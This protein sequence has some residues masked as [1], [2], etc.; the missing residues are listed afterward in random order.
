MLLVLS[1]QFSIEIGYLLFF[2]FFLEFGRRR[3]WCTSRGTCH[4]RLC[5]GDSSFRRFLRCID[6]ASENRTPAFYPTASKWTP[7]FAD[8][9]GASIRNRMRT[10]VGRWQPVAGQTRCV[11]VAS[12]IS[13]VNE[14]TQSRA[15]IVQ[16]AL[17]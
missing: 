6:S 5:S 14:T 7:S 3:H 16:S 8:K 1:K 2:I 15:L 11:R 17:L 10:D 9:W 4:F 13:T 12:T